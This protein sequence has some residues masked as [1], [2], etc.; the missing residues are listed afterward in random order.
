M[1]VAARHLLLRGTHW[2]KVAV[3]Q[4]SHLFEST[5]VKHLGQQEAVAVDQELFSSYQF[6]VDQ[7]MEL[8][9]LACAQAVSLT[10]P[11]SPVPVLVCCGP[12]NNGG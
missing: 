11:V 3:T 1:I 8:A 5:M 2:R 6:S 12:G 4:C 9:G 10:Y 7:L